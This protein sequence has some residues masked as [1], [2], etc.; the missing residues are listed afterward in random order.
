MRKTTV[1]LTALLTWACLGLSAC[2]AE[3]GWEDLFDGK[4]LNGWVQRNGKARYTVEGGAIVGTTVT[5]TPNSFLCTEK[6]YSDFILELEFL[7]ADRMNSGIQIRSNSYR[8]YN[9]YRVHGYQVEIDPSDRA[10][11]G[12]IYDEGRRGWLFDLKEKPEAQKAFRRGQW[13]HYRVEA[14]GDRI[15]TWVN[16]VPAADLTDGMTRTG[17]IALQVHSSQTAG[18]QIRWRNIRIMDLA[19]V[20]GRP[21]LKALIIDGQNNHDWAAT[22]PY[23]KAI[24]E[25]T[26]L[27][28]V[29]V[30]TSP[31]A[32]KPMDDFKPPFAGNDVVVLNYTGDDWSGQTQQAFLDYVRNGGGVVVFHAANNAFP[33]WK[34]YNEII[35]LGGWGGRNEKSGPMVRWKD[36]RMV[37]DHSPGAGGTHGPQ[38]EFAVETRDADHPIMQGLP[39]KWLTVRDEL[40]SKLRGPAENLRVLATAY[41][42]PGQQGTGEHEPILF[43]VGWDE[44]RVFHTVLGHG[45]EQCRGVGFIV[46]LQRGAEWAATGRVTQHNVPSDFP[47]ADRTTIRPSPQDYT[48]IRKYDFEQSRATLAAIEAEIRSVPIG[49]FDRIESRLLEELAAPETTFAGKQFICR[50]LREVGSARCVPALSAMLPDKELSH[51][52]RWALQMIPAP[53]AGQALVAALKTTQ[54]DLRIGVVGSLGSR[55][56]RVAVKPI[57]ALIGEDG[58]AALTAAA[59]KALGRIGGSEAAE[60]LIAAKTPVELKSPR[61]DSLLR[62]ADSLLDNGEA[63]A[64]ARIYASMTDPEYATPVRIAAYRGLMLA[65]ADRAVPAVLALLKDSDLKL[66]EAAGKFMTEMPGEGITKALAGELAGLGPQAQVVLI[67]A[68]EAR[69]DKTAAASVAAMA[70]AG[71]PAV[72]LAAVNALGVLATASH[73]EMLATISAESGELGRA[74]ARSISRIA[75]A[76]APAIL[77]TLAT[78]HGQP[79]VRTTVINAIVDRRQ[80]TAS[81][82]LL[83]AAGDSEAG[84]RKAAYRAIGALGGEKDIPPLVENLIK[85]ESAADRSDIER[86]IVSIVSRTKDYDGAAII[87]GLDTASDEVKMSLLNTLPAVGSDK[88]LSAVRTALSAGGEVGKAA[89]RALAAWPN[90]APLDDLLEVAGKDG[91]ATTRVIALRGYIKLVSLPANRRSADTVKLL[92]AAFQAAERPDEKRAV[93]SL[94]PDYACD[95]SLALAERAKT[96]SAL[97][98]EAEQAVS[99]I[100]SVLLNKSL[101]VS[102]SLNSNAAGRAIDGDPGTRW[103][104]GRGM[105]PG[106]WFM[107]DLGVD[108]KVK[109]LVLDCR[110]SDGDYPRGYEVY[111]SFDAGNWGTPIVTGKSDNP[112][113]KIDFGKTVSARFIRI[114]QT[115][116]VPTLFWSIHELTV[117]FE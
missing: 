87:A 4:T 12:G 111:A 34:E 61:D 13:N 17:F 85:S 103:D 109:G 33:N 2:R 68:L 117:E 6:M 47:T 73:I 14:I 82:A 41:A 116:S 86:A 66:Q 80:V 20:R 69:G 113:T 94:L 45:P 55:R 98:K 54:G 42:D 44:G 37:L 72:R 48:A 60:A 43:T 79:Q 8:D 106:D 84:V 52:A 23:L 114:V 105:T 74:A 104:T 71:E 88:A 9:N 31:P 26:G 15:R 89:V 30:A 100:R 56:E 1:L 36:G 95:E 32:G 24:L 92:Q 112:L 38:H 77:E 99:K 19:P 108:G 40:Y 75:D 35:G 22:T 27:F 93:L 67:G 49:A 76:K 96:D 107:I 59:I 29:Q 97:A 11:S 63:D 62:C 110:G 65:D 57:S 115:G 51:V 10:W 28:S 91:D 102:A 39:R 5:G 18:Q 64:A 25:D 101:K 50:C 16:G 81:G 78:S 7:V 21:Y 53:E 90:P 58:E 83:K 70:S 46:T 3:K